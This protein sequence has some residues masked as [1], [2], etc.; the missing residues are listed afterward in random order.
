MIDIHASALCPLANLGGASSAVW[1][2]FV[3][4]GVFMVCLVLLSIVSISVIIYKA[5]NMKRAA[6]VPDDVAGEMQ[7]AEHWAEQNNM[8]GLARL[9]QENPSTLSRIGL[10]ALGTPFGDKDEAKGAVQAHAREEIAD[11]ESGIALLEVVITVA[12]LL[13]LLGTVSGLVSVFSSLDMTGDNSEHARI[14]NGIAE[15]LNT[16]I[17]GLAVAVPTVFAHSYFTKKIERMALR[18]EVLVGHLINVIFRYQH[19]QLPPMSAPDT[20]KKNNVIFSDLPEELDDD[21]RP[22]LDPENFESAPPPSNT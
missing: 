15:A 13:G 5:L 10:F 14:A 17:A 21:E 1:S 22:I 20:E 7:R 9:M 11:A 12:P 6:I 3:N 16:T 18:M 4:G 2:F 19:G 8:P